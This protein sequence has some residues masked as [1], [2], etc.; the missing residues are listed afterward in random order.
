[1]A[2]NGHLPLSG[3]RVVDFSVLAAGPAAA[4]MLADYGAQ[5]ICVESERNIANAGGSRQ[6]G[7]PGLSPIN[8]AWFHN[9]YN[10]GKLSVTIDLSTPQGKDVMKRLIAVSDVFVANRTPQVLRN[11]GLAYDTLR[12]VRPELIY[13]AMPTMGEGGPR[14]FYGGVSW[15]IQALAGLNM[16]SGFPDRPPASPSPY[17]HPDVS[18]NP[19]QAAVAILAALRYRRRTGKGQRIELSQYES[20]IC[21][22]GAAVLQYTANGTPLPQPENRH[23]AAAPHDVYRC[24]GD[25]AWCAISVFTDQQWAGLCRV[26][27]R[28]ELGAHADYAT[29]SGRKAHEGDLRGIIEPWT[30]ERPPEEVAQLLQEAGVPCA[31]VNNFEQLLKRDPQ[32]LGRQLWRE[33]EHPELGTALVEDWGFRL[34]GAPP[35][36]PRRAPLLGEHNDYVF[37]EVVGLDED[38]VN[39]YLVEGVFR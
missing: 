16:I 12:E 6:S 22:T 1:V 5:V 7:P 2:A 10:P 8:T 30:A 27:E 18:C 39:M 26:I 17:S 23:E 35:A 34:S 4:K 28:P 9:K 31:P 19:L 21:W 32:L 14:S 37:Q 20:T 25:D 15:G 38:E 11:L 29:L 3:I 13:L 36:E 33:V 24:Q